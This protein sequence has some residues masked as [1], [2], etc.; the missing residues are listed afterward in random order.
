MSQ[1]TTGLRSILSSPA[2]Y[3][4]LQSLMGSKEGTREFIREWVRPEAGLRFLDIGC[5]TARILDYLPDVEYFGFDLS[6]RYI[7][8]A[9]LRYGDRGHFH[10]ARVE[11]A[12][13]RDLPRFDIVFASGVIHH[14]DDGDALGLFRLADASLKEGGRLVSIDPCFDPG[15]NP[16][17]RFLIS[18]D[19]GQNVRTADQYRQLAQS[20]FTNISGAIRHQAW[21]PYTHWIMECTK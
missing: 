10:C 14:L 2:I 3:D 17:A 12:T 11:E 4:A 8:H 21:I 15:Q 9:K 19:R 20:V 16:I 1:V 18:K 6:Q 7:D 13:L 5:G